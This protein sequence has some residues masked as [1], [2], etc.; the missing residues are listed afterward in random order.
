VAY[1]TSSEYTERTGQAAPADRVLEVAS[2]TVDAA[3][4]GAVYNVDD[5]GAPTDAAVIAALRDATIEQALYMVESGDTT[6]AADGMQSM[7]I[8]R[9][10]WTRASGASAS[11]KR[12]CSAA[13]EIL[14]AAG[15][16]PV[17]VTQW[18]TTP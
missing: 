14:H 2:T 16:V 18:L 5:D 12:L 13:S 11:R 8:G 9:V 17:A 6:G 10:S 1:A 3:L 7:S 4:I 15:L